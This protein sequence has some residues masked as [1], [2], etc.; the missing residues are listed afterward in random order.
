MMQRLDQKG[1]FAWKHTVEPKSR[2]K[3]RS[4]SPGLSRIPEG[5]QA[6]TA[7]QKSSS[8]PYAPRLETPG[9]RGYLSKWP[10]IHH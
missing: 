3:P 9:E 10:K 8:P 1:S 5:L 7:A 4:S 2:P 6:H